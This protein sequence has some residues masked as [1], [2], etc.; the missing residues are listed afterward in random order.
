MLEDGTPARHLEMYC[1]TS[2]SS[3]RAGLLPLDEGYDRGIVS[4]LKSTVGD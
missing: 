3:A 4:V 2:K 1:G